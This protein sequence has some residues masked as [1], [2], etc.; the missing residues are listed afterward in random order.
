M[1]TKQ[2][3]INW[4]VTCSAIAGIVIL[5]GIALCMGHNGVLF[6]T[7]CVIIAGLAGYKI[8]N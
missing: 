2:N 5:D 3:R 4:K 7:S 1:M 6:T 8:K